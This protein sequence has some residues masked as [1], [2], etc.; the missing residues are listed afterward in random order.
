MSI[1]DS[2]GTMIEGG[3][4]ARAV[5]PKAGEARPDEPFEGACL[6]C[7]TE[8]VGPHCHRCGQKAHIHTTM[9]EFLHDL[10]HGTLHIE[11][12]TFHTV[13]LLAWRPGQLTRRYIDGQRARFVS[14]MALFLASVFLMFAVFQFSGITPPDDLGP[15]AAFG[16]GDDP[17]T[18]KNRLDALKGARAAMSGSNPAAPILDSQIKQAEAQVAAKAPVKPGQPIVLARSESGMTLSTKVTGLAFI[19]KGIQKW[20]ENPGLMAY[21]L[22]S[23]FYK[24][25]WL[26]I[27]L[28]L[29]FV[30]LLFFWKRQ[31]RFGMYDHAVFVTY[32]ISFMTLFFVALVLLTQAGLG[33]GTLGILLAIVPPL[34]LYKQL[35]GTYG[36]RRFSALWRTF[37]LAVFIFVIL[38]LF[39][40]VLLVLGAVG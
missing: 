16:S 28:S 7:G 20:R 4:F 22:Q 9:K 6:N 18:A 36:L 15:P 19:D 17:A 31:P 26:L 35:K 5:E 34:H 12:K 24:F 21:K 10:V 40:D 8:R 33:A 13:P 38:F 1:I 11:G 27:P 2:L 14:P 3:L 23:N 30:W 29:P 37:M 39:L 32:S 25:S